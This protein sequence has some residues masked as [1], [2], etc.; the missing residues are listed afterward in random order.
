M[1]KV[2]RERSAEDKFELKVFVVLQIN[3][4]HR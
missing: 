4:Q 2:D 1:I 3:A